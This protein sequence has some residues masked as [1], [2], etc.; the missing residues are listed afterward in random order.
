MTLLES[1]SHGLND[2]TEVRVAGISEVVDVEKQVHLEMFK[3][4]VSYRLPNG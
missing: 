1:T 3:G 4:E 2:I